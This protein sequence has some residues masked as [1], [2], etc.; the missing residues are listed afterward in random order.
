VSRLYRIGYNALVVAYGRLV[1]AVPLRLNSR[2]PHFWQ[3]FKALSFIRIQ[4][5]R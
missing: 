1:L 4:F 2:L 3:A 5:L